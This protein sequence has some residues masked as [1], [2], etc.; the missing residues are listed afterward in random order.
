M[1]GFNLRDDSFIYPFKGSI[2]DVQIWDKVLTASEIQ[3]WSTCQYPAGGNFVDWSKAKFNITGDIKAEQVAKDQL[4]KSEETKK[5]ISFSHLSEF[6][7][8]VKFCKIIGGEI[9]VADTWSHKLEMDQ[10]L[11][12]GCPDMYYSGFTKDNNDQWVNVNTQEIK[13]NLSWSK[14]TYDD[15]CA[16]VETKV[17]DLSFRKDHCFVQTCPICELQDWPPL[18]QLR[19]IH[20]DE[21]DNFYYLLNSTH[22]IGSTSE[23]V[24][25]NSSWQIR[26]VETNEVLGI[27]DDTSVEEND[28]STDG[29]G[30]RFPI[31]LQ[32]WKF[33]SSNMTE[34]KNLVYMV[35]H[36][37]I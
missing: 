9:S 23:M 37:N 24:L 27:I 33:R 12:Q 28:A 36:F 21:I 1:N 25:S 16:L 20:I 5:I 8:S 3:K 35:C 11:G 31:G 18:L 7:E 2:T 17:T 32:R 30:T 13:T 29:Q 14:L 6:V 10:A 19:G 15:H 34:D 22:L 26:N 4:C